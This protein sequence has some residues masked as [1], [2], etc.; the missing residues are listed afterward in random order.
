[1]SGFDAY[2]GG[3]YGT[4]EITADTE[5]VVTTASYA[6][7]DKGV[8]TDVATLPSVFAPAD[9]APVTFGKV[10]DRAAATSW[11]IE[12]TKD[13]VG[14]TP[15]N[16][17]SYLY[18]ALATNANGQYA[19]EFIGLEPGEYQIRSYVYVDGTATYGAPATFVVE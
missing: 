4:G 15:A 9:A 18:K 19:I 17:G 11:G 13:G 16:G 3:T 5:I 7:N 2:K 1:F 10:L 8:A 12:L 6:A 14:V